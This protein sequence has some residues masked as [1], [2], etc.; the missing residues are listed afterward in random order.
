MTAPGEPPESYFDDVQISPDSQ[1]LIADVYRKVIGGFDDIEAYAGSLNDPAERAEFVAFVVERYVSRALELQ[2]RAND[3]D[4]QADQPAV[5]SV[6]AVEADDRRHRRLAQVVAKLAAEVG[7]E[8]HVGRPATDRAHLL[9][10]WLRT[11]EDFASVIRGA[12]NEAIVDA[13]TEGTK[14]LTMARR[15]GL[16][17]TAVLK[18][19]DN[20]IWGRGGSAGVR[21]LAGAVAILVM[22]WVDSLGLADV[23]PNDLWPFW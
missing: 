17:K 5:V 13:L 4:A 3:L 23:M 14:P 16:S 8:S 18:I 20:P 7:V 19:R 15:L 11:V 21:A 1:A 22:R 10:V 9:D 12:R 2:A 6:A